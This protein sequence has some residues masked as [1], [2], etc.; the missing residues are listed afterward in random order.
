MKIIILKKR[1]EFKMVID[2]AKKNHYWY[3]LINN[4]K[5]FFL[6]IMN[7]ANRESKCPVNIEKSTNEGSLSAD[8]DTFT[9]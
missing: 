1:V 4:Y 3:H 8:S 9:K 6:N 2:N 5:I 7:S